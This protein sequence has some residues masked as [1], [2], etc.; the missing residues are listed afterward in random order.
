M[1]AR[2]IIKSRGDNHDGPMFQEVVAMFPDARRFSWHQNAFDPADRYW[3]VG[4]PIEC[5][6]GPG[7]KWEP[8]PL[9]MIA[10]LNAVYEAAK[11]AIQSGDYCE[12]RR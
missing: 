12:D 1:N 4:S 8:V 9:E 7:M 5:G 10:A 6:G 3:H 2:R 11:V